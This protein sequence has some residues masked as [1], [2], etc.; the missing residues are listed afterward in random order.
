MK[1]ICVF[2]CVIVISCFSLTACFDPLEALLLFPGN[3][4]LTESLQP[5]TQ[6]PSKWVSE[7][8]SIWFEVY[9]DE[10]FVD[11]EILDE[12][13]DVVEYDDGLR[14]IGEAEIDG[15][16]YDVRIEIGRGG[17]FYIYEIDE[18]KNEDD[19]MWFHGIPSYHN[20]WFTLETVANEDDMYHGKYN[21][22]KFVRV[23]DAEST[24]SERG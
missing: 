16:I 4:N 15:V 11:A 5:N 1:K 18:E 7:E 20:G 2:L 17:T 23:D 6:A 13:G 14:M 22:I 10:R 8:P 19:L 9:I 24:A 12:D 3:N 21:E